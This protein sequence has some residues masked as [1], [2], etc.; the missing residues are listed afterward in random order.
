MTTIFQMIAAGAALLALFYF[1]GW[2]TTPNQR[3]A[4][5]ARRGWGV[6][7]MLTLAVG[8][9]VLGDYLVG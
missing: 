1:A 3:H 2:V 6:V 5:K 8:S 4:V 7:A 9:L